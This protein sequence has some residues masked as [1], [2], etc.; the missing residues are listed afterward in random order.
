M[1]PPTGRVRA[2]SIAMQKGF[3][4][5][6]QGA[7]W[8]ISA[9]A[10][11]AEIGSTDGSCSP[12]VRPARLPD[13]ACRLPGLLPA[14][15]AAIWPAGRPA[16]PERGA[17]APALLF[18]RERAAGYARV[19]PCPS[20]ARSIAMAVSSSRCQSVAARFSVQV[21]APVPSVPLA[22]NVRITFASSP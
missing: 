11:Q 21:T 15:P 5:A 9:R 1:R 12:L 2:P 8:M 3:H 13:A 20:S 6:A 18:Y 22:L 10:M 16:R 7:P 14:R 4:H 17:C 19:Q